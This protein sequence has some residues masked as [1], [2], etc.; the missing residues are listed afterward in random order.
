MH[1]THE[2]IKPVID[3]T[4]NCRKDQRMIH[5]MTAFM[6]VC[7]QFFFSFL[8]ASCNMH[9]CAG[10]LVLYFKENSSLRRVCVL[11]AAP[12]RPAVWC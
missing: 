6:G 4:E 12:L 7:P 3:N 8:S 10:A 9:S 1:E 2:L 5:F 11:A